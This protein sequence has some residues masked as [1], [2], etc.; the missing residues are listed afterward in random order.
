MEVNC[1]SCSMMEF[2]II[3]KLRNLSFIH[4]AGDNEDNADSNDRINASCGGYAELLIK[5]VPE[6]LTWEGAIND[7]WYNDKNWNQSTEKELH[8]GNKTDMMITAM[9]R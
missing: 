3:S 6:Y 9:I 8:K 4:T 7:A 5:I 1:L 2:A